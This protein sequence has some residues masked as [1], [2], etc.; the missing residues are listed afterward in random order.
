MELT[1]GEKKLIKYLKGKGYVGAEELFKIFDKNE[2]TSSI[3]WLREK[4]IIS[5]LEKPVTYYSIG[6]E[7]EKVLT[8]GLPEENLLRFYNSGQRSTVELERSMGDELRYGLAQVFRNGG[9]VVNGELVIEGD[10]RIRDQILRTR[11]ALEMVRN[12]KLSEQDAPL[13]KPRKGF[14]NEKVRMER[15]V[16]LTAVGEQVAPELLEESDEINQITPEIIEKF[17]DKMSLRPYDPT[18][19]APRYLPG[20]IH[21]LSEFIA[22]VR[23]V[24]LEMGFKELKGQLVETAFWNMDMLFIPQNHPARDMQDTFYLKGEGE[25][26]P[27]QEKKVKRVHER[28]VAGSRGWQYKWSKEEASKLLLRTHTTVNTIRYIVEHP[29][30]ECKIF[31]VEKIFRRENVDASHL[32]EFSQVE[33]VIS[34]RGVTFGVLMDTLETFYHRLGV[35]DIR[36]KPS[37]FPYTEPSLEVFGT[38]KGKDMELGGAGMFRPE[39][40]KP[41]GIKY[42]VAAW[43]LGLER[44]LMTV[45]NLE[46]IRD[47]YRNDLSFLKERKILKNLFE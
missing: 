45:L 29:A 32:A 44:L 7:G 36:V 16:K 23:E 47:I 10:Q 25:L 22:E 11:S 38:F 39:V 9:R 19:Y 18:L 28:G 3:S 2:V 13:L 41:W 43:G 37:Y 34:G 42:N 8:S 20:K 33:G 4:K 15:T 46:D 27:S 26:D 5:V 6:S 14:I 35:K 12:G 30:E 17:N 31:S 24:M 40:L 21:P 1:N